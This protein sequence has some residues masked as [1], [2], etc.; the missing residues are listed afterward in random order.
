M[1]RINTALTLTG[2]NPEVVGKHWQGCA[3][4]GHRHVDTKLGQLGNQDRQPSSNGRFAAG[5]T[6]R[7]DAC[8]FDKNPSDT[9]DLFKR[10]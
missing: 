3:V 2:E 9:F 10:Q 8:V 5:E 1:P 4:C 7:P 6:D